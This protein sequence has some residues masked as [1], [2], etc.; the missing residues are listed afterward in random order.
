MTRKSQLVQ[1]YEAA[2]AAHQHTSARQY[3]WARSM[4]DRHDP[5]AA[6]MQNQA[7]YHAHVARTFLDRALRI[8]D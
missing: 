8:I 3:E 7:A 4:L 2:A 5:R 1:R 6:M